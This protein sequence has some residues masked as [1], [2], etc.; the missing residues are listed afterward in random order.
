MA[1]SRKHSR[2]LRLREKLDINI[3]KW[4][5]TLLK[6]IQHFTDQRTTTTE[7]NGMF[8]GF[9]TIFDRH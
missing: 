4:S 2:M 1:Q 9:L 5:K 6:R 3:N 8:D 7:T